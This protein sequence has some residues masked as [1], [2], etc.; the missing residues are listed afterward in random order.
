MNDRQARAEGWL[1]QVRSEGG[2]IEPEWW[3]RMR[4]GQLSEEAT[5]A[6][7]PRLAEALRAQVRQLAQRL[8]RPETS[9]VAQWT[10]WLT[11]KSLPDE[12]PWGTTAGV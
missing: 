8:G 1:R 9:G 12:P 5:L 6:R 4:C 11:R 7:A 10:V 3:L 2:S